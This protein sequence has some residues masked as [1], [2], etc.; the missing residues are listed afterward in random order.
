M[1]KIKIHNDM[2]TDLGK[3]WTVLEYRFRECSTAVE[4]VLENEAGEIERRVISAMEF[5]WVE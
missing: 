3:V 2:W 1:K 5:E 4:F